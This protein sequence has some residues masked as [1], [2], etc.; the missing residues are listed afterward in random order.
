M[1]SACAPV[2]VTRILACPVTMSRRDVV[3]DATHWVVKIGSSVFL[4]DDRHVDRPTFASLV[5]GIDG[6]LE[7]GRG[8][9]VV[10]SGAVALGREHLGWPEDS[11]DIAEQQALAALGQSRLVQMYES[12]FAHYG[13]RAA[14]ILFSRADLDDRERFLNARRALERLHRFEAVPI[15]NENDSV[16]T[17]ELHFGDNDRLAAMTCAVEQ[18]DL[19]VLLSDV[20]GICRIDKDDE[21]GVRNLGDR[22]SSISVGDPMLDEVAG[23]SQTEV[24][25]G[26]M[27]SK[28]VASRIAARLDVP[29]VVAPGKRR[30]VLLELATGAD[31]GTLLTPEGDREYGGKR[32]WLASSAR[33]AGAVIVDP[34]ARRAIQRDG[35]SLLPTGVVAVEGEFSEGSVVELRTEDDGGFG[36]GIAVYAADEV[37]QIA[38]QQ[39]TEIES[40]LGYRTLDC[41]VHRDSMALV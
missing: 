26:G 1:A 6:L 5:E 32:A 33:T 27:T 37:R 14:Q 38:G 19:L 20:R 16:A 39:S 36:R 10:S 21:T 22:I 15:I 2:V 25:T 12:E 31:V 24:G 8:V 4:R 7:Q 41:V 40:I 11:E 18:A 17:E 23:P 34:G 3:T 13:R 9:T 29:T 30:E 28:V 35:A